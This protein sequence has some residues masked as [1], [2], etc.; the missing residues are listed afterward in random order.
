MRISIFGLGYVGSVTAACLAEAGHEVWGV[1]VSADKVGTVNAGKSP[2]VEHRVEEMMSRASERG[3]LRA[4]SDPVAAVAATELTL[5]CVGTP[6]LPNGNTDL[7]AMLGVAAQIGAALAAKSSRHCV[8][9]RST[10]PPG[11]IRRTLIPALEQASGRT[12]HRDFD[13]CMHPE[14]LREGTAVADF[15]EPP[16]IVI[17]A[18]T[19]SGGDMVAGLP[20][21]DA[22]IERTNYEAAELLKYSCN[23]FHALKVAF[24]NE[25]GT[26]AKSLGVDGHRVMQL[27]AMDRKLNVSPAYLKPGFAFGGSCL[28][29]DLR[30]LTYTARQHDLALPL[31]GSILESNRLHLERALQRILATGEKRIGILGLSFKVGADDLRESP[32]VALIEVL[33][34]KGFQVKIYDPDV[35]LATIFGANKRFIEKEIPHISCLMSSDLKEVIDESDVIVVSKPSP[36]FQAALS[37]HAGD[38]LIYDLARVSLNGAAQTMRYRRDLLVM[39]GGESRQSR[40]VLPLLRPGEPNSPDTPAFPGDPGERPESARTERRTAR[41]ARRRGY[42]MRCGDAELAVGRARPPGSRARRERAAPGAGA[43]ARGRGRALD[44]CSGRLGGQA[45]V[46]RR[47]D[48]RVPPHRASRARRGLGAVSVG[49]PAGSQARRDPV[50]D[51]LEQALPDPAGIRSAALQLVSEVSQA[52]FRAPCGDDASRA[53]QS[54]RVSGGQLVHLLWLARRA[55]GRRFPLFGSIRYDGSFGKRVRGEDDRVPDPIGR[56]PQMVRA[57]RRSEGTAIAGIKGAGASQ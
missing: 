19:T 27:F 10:V 21:I 42:R 53:R 22:P 30:L 12:A 14:F 9:F 23:A 34:G 57:R 54:R 3:L 1:D 49:V 38:K 6:S 5:V 16:F 4:T 31:L 18:E 15:Y 29:K 33:I 20:G 8:V 24:A 36:E 13:V 56:C 40:A 39:T 25:M 46:G 35:M 44:R 48:G 26:L 51:H 52:S 28:P 2:V 7:S 55:A 32:S 50:L 45:P 43:P 11:T 47:V 17:G 37:T 41:R